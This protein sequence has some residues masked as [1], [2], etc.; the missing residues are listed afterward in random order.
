MLPLILIFV[1]LGLGVVAILGVVAFLTGILVAV[2]FLVL[3][4]LILYVFFKLNMIDDDYKW[5][6]IVAPFIMFFVGLGLD[7]INV[8]K[9]QPLSVST[10][11]SNPLSLPLELILL[12]ILVILGIANIYVE[13]TEK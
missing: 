7:R 11:V 10:L 5:T 13:V 8:L 4:F 9:I 6:L 1:L 12:I 3:T 2:E